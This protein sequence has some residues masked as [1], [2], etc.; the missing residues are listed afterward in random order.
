MNS[1][2][3]KRKQSDFKKCRNWQDMFGGSS[4]LCCGKCCRKVKVRNGL[5]AETEAR[6]DVPRCRFC[7]GEMKRVRLDS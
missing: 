7:D 1:Y 2:V 6:G 5:L 3:R 4:L